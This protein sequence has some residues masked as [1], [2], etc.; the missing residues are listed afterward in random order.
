MALSLGTYGYPQTPYKP[1]YPNSR[2][3]FENV[4][5]AANHV[6]DS[7]RT[8]YEI[9]ADF[10]VH[11][12]SMSTSIPHVDL[13]CRLMSSAIW[14]LC[15]ERSDARVAGRLRSLYEHVCA[16]IGKQNTRDHKWLQ[17][18]L[19]TLN[20]TV[21]IL[22]T[23]C[24]CLN[25]NRSR[26]KIHKHLSPLNQKMR[27]I[28]MRGHVTAACEQTETVIQ[29]VCE[30]M[31]AH[32]GDPTMH[33]STYIYLLSHDQNTYIGRCNCIRNSKT[34][35]GG[36]NHRYAEHIRSMTKHLDSTVSETQ[37]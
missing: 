8:P 33:R 12:C 21:Y 22:E 31:R 36:A 20:F 6:L 3:N 23:S 5:Q 11:K 7:F 29:F 32:A 27:T 18:L 1:T 10:Y 19:G 17:I 2:F 15:S 28:F 16:Q 24:F 9:P 13:L 35:G 37:R 25:S 34:W 30:Q 4:V 26:K 14:N